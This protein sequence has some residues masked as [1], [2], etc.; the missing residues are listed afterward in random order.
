[1]PIES[2]KQSFN[3]H[4][5]GLNLRLELRTLL[6]CN[7]CCDNWSRDSTSSPKS[8]FGTH[9]YVR[10][11]LVLTQKRQVK[12][13]L[14]WLSICSHHNEFRNTSV[15]GFGGCV[16]NK[17]ELRLLESAKDALCLYNVNRVSYID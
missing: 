15:Q 14:Q 2:N 3:G 11:V 7:G 8:L 16:E 5:Y 12:D 9:E 1:M 10:D 17:D 4:L 13:Y 6:D